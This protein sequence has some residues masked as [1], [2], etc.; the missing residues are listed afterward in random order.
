MVRTYGAPDQIN[1]EVGRDLKKIMTSEDKL[2]SV[3]K[4]RKQN[5]PEAK[6]E[7]TKEGVS[8][9]NKN[10]LKY[11][12]YQQQN[13][14]CVYSG[15]AIDL[16]RLDENGYCDID[17]IIP[18]SRSL[19]DSQNNKVLCLA[20]ENR[21]KGS[22]TPYEYLQPLGRWEEFETI[23]NTT[24]SIN[25][26]K[27]NNLLNKTY[28]EQEED[29]AFRERNANDNSYI[30]RYVKQYLEDGIDFSASQWPIKTRIQVR[31]GSLTDYLR[32]QWGLIKNRDAGDKHHAQDAIVIACATQGMVQKL[33]GLSAVF[34]NKEAFR[35]RKAEELGHEKAEAW[36]KYIK[37]QI[38]EPWSGFRAEVMNKL[39][40]V[41]VSRPPRKNA[42]GAAHKD[43][44]FSNNK[45]KGSLPIRNGMAEK[46]NMFRL[47]VFQK[48]G[49]LY[50]VPIY[51]VDL[52]SGKQFVDA[53]QPN[54]YSDDCLVTIN[55]DFNFKFSLY[56]DDYVEINS[57]DEH[58]KG[59]VNQYNAQSG[60]LYIGSTDNSR[61]YK[62][63]TSTFEQGDH[64]I[65]EING[66]ERIGEIGA[67]DAEN[68]KIIIEGWE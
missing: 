58:I 53:P 52:V 54:E 16:R 19:D 25:R 26:L 65:L 13:G 41:F 44:I 24:P 66:E 6:D 23:I 50:I 62:I 51:V 67:F 14:K 48:E 9:S 27:R 40:Q 15:K 36:Y 10:V 33:S 34:E 61:L 59:Y 28:K 2:S 8:A 46:E 64:I 55:A 60:Q 22:Q 37:R 57:G 49:R 7:L 12:L 3:R 4:K 31:T 11:R 32:H 38:Q 43:T 42:T 56:K 29:V 20:E 39:D 35:K 68:Q 21:K 30:A 17:H 47:D 18:Y 63:K 5:V 45:N 1:L